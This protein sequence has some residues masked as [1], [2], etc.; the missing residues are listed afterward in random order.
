MSEVARLWSNQGLSVLHRDTLVF[1]SGF[2]PGS[3]TPK[4]CVLFTALRHH[5]P[6]F[7]FIKHSKEHLFEIESFCNIINVFTVNF[8]Q[9]NASLKSMLFFLIMLAH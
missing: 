7:L 2:K 1:N 3:L 9:F 6:I 5:H 4:A 8:D